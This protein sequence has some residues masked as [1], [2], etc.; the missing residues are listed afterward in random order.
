V[1]CVDEQGPIQ[2]I[3]HPGPG[4]QSKQHPLRLAAHYPR[5]GSSKHIAAF[6]P[7]TGEVAG[8][9]LETRVRGEEL[10]AFIE[11]T[12]RRLDA[13][14]PDKRFALVMDNLQVH[15]TELV[16]SKLRPYGDRVL[17]CYTPT[18]ASWLNLIES[19]FSSLSRAVLRNSCPE[20]HADVCR[21]IGSYVEAW[22][23]DPR[24]YH[25]PKQQRVPRLAQSYSTWTYRVQYCR[26]MGGRPTHNAVKARSPHPNGQRHRLLT[27]AKRHAYRNYRTEFPYTEKW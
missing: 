16:Q 17:V 20:S 5:P 6:C 3:P 13:Q 8:S 2:W 1:V 27:Q 18:S 4:W 26:P 21:L 22:R 23:A 14:Y 11:S 10:A 7:H 19:W 24:A 15:K 12:L 9:R 25:W